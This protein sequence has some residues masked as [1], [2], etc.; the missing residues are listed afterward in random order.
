MGMKIGIPRA[1]LYYRYHTL[2]ETFFTA[3]GHEIV[4]SEETSRELLEKG[5]AL[6]IDE[7][8]LSAKIWFGHAGSLVGRCDALFVPR[9]ASFGRLRYMC[10]RFEALP[11]LTRCVFRQ[12]GQR[13]VDCNVDVLN[14]CGE[15]EAYIRLAQEL[16]ATPREAKSAWKEARRA[17]DKE[18]KNVVRQEDALSR[19]EGLKVLLAAHSYVYEDAWIG[20]PVTAFLEKSGITV[21]HADRVDRDLALRYSE[22]ISPTCRWEVSREIM[23]GIAQRKDQVNGVILMSAFPCGPDA[24]VND[25]CQRKFPG[26]PMLNLTLDG[27]SGSAGQE[28]RLESFT[29]IIRFKEGLM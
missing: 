25:M 29:D 22:V 7:T 21:L 20:R 16:G 1:M 15:A 19:R 6:C 8:C 11:D 27:Q 12:S 14:G 4:L 13:I 2:W 17:A 18:W 3:L 26:L 5:S 9:I 23:G 28:T 10:T 24:M